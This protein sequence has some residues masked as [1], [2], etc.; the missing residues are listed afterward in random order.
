[1]LVISPTYPTRCGNWS[2]KTLIMKSITKFSAFLLLIG[3]LCYTSFKKEYSC[4]FFFIPVNYIA[5]EAFSTLLT[6]ILN[7]LPIGNSCF[8]ISTLSA[9]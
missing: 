2:F 3:V 7:N 5:E 4:A 8:E 6:S 1:M 9:L